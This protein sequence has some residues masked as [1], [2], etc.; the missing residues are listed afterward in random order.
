[1][2]PI[3]ILGVAAVG[4]SV[5][6]AIASKNAAKGAEATVREGRQAFSD[7]DLPSIEDQ[8]L[9]LDLMEQQGV[10][11]P[12]QRQVYEQDPSAFQNI[13]SD[14]RLKQAQ[15][16]ALDTLSNISNSNGLDAQSQAA[17]AQA[18]SDSDVYA[19]GQREAA[20]QNAAARGISGSGLELASSLQ[21]G[22]DAANRY[23]IT[24]T[25]AA[26]EAERRKMDA[27]NSLSTLSGNV[28][29]QDYTEASQRAQ[30]IDAINRF[31]T[32]NRSDVNASN[33]QANNNAQVANLQEKQRIA[34]QN[35]GLQN[36]QQQ[37]NKELQQQNF[38]NQM[39]KAKGFAG[40]S[41]NVANA[42][43]EGGKAVAGALGGIGQ[44]LIGAGT[45][46]YA[47]KGK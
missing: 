44:S 11:T 8:K 36:S 31:N 42:Q 47:N 40:Q 24:G 10:I 15:L 13:Q 33:V 20:L 26:A 41:S 45:T 38:S 5:A 35:I 9:Q 6:G 27:L 28:R 37:Y 25:Q 18:R 1:M 39:E 21:A 7:V 19:R 43:L 46:L 4:A 30:A 32:Q 22:Q 12:E 16:D 14:P 2:P 29:N 23:A 3:A 34:D 17:Q